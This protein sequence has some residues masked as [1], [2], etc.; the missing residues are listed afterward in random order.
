M[1]G[2]WDRMSLR[3]RIEAVAPVIGVDMADPDRNVR[4]DI[5]SVARREMLAWVASCTDARGGR[6]TFAQLSRGLGRKKGVV[7]KMVK[8]RGMH[9]CTPD[10]SV[11]K[12][13]IGIALSEKPRRLGTSDIVML[14]G[15]VR[16]NNWPWRRG[17]AFAHARKEANEPSA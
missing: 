9:R 17:W 8:M 14:Y 10:H 16:E 3:E 12:F 4:V 7:Y 1:E 2:R 13:I 6:P 15:A 11:A 5:E